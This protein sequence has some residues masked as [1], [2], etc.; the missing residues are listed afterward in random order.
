MHTIPERVD[1]KFRLVLLAA[2]RAEQLMRGAR[3]KIEGGATKPTRLALDEVSQDLVAWDYGYPP[4][5][6]EG[7]EGVDGEAEIADLP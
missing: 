2:A 6:V 5:A 4:E 7:I 1:S 3:P